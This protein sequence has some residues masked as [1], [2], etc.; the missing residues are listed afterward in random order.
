MYFYF[1]NEIKSVILLLVKVK[2]LHIVDDFI[3]K[4]EMEHLKTAVRHWTG[5]EANTITK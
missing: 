5:P 2:A 4:Y 3:E 1:S